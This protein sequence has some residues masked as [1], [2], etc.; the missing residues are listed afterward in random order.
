MSN[1]LCLAV[2]ILQNF[3]GFQVLTFESLIVKLK[4]ENRMTGKLIKT[5]FI[6]IDGDLVDYLSLYSCFGLGR[7]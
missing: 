7:H 1:Y 3:V 4:V 6:S 2:C 5:S